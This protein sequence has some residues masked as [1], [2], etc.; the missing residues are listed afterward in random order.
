MISI[1]HPNII[2]IKKIV[3]TSSKDISQL[4]TNGPHF[5]LY[6]EPVQFE[7]RFLTEKHYEYGKLF[8]MLM[9]LDF[10]GILCSIFRYMEEMNVFYAVKLGDIGITVDGN[11]KVYIPPQA[12]IQP[13]FNQ[14][15]EKAFQSILEWWE[16]VQKTINNIN[17]N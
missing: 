16:N 4:K 7:I 12:I 14:K 15:I 5:T 11:I 8:G 2:S 10:R 6:Y 3:K 13:K 1:N 17:K 9:G